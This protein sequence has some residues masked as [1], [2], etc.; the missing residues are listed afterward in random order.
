V[1]IVPPEPVPGCTHQDVSCL[2]PYD[3]IRKYCCHGCGLVMMCACKETFARR[4]LPHQLLEGTELE[5]QLHVSVTGGFQVGVCNSSRGHPE[6]PHPVAQ[7]YGRNSKVARYYWLEIWFETTRQFADWFEREG[8][9]RWVVTQRAH[10]DE[11]KAIQRQVTD[12][13]RER[14]DLEPNYRYL[15]QSQSEVL[16]IES[17][18]SN[19]T[20]ST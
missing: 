15:E 5:T 16:T 9:G 10:E 12:E 18:W 3:L 4:F 11:Y 8:H 1:A 20:A 7:A 13:I 17:K 6:D 19:Q 2:N 14:H